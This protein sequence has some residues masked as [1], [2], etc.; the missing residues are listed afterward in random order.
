M[1]LSRDQT[2]Y[3]LLPIIDAELWAGALVAAS[4]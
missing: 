2:F 3:H 1:V 4:P